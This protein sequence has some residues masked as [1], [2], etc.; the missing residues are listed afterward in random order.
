[1]NSC[2]GGGAHATIEVTVELKRSVRTRV[3]G[4]A[5]NIRSSR[6][7]GPIGS[8]RGPKETALA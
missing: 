2:E 7:K 5:T 4:I 6:V 1:V 8:D 3:G